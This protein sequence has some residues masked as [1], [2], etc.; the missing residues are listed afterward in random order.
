M[1][2]VFYIFIKICSFSVNID[3]KFAII[4][5]HHILYFDVWT[6]SD[7]LRIVPPIFVYQDS[8]EW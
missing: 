7:A 1:L 2:Y 8:I 3:F 4:Y 5:S 6:P